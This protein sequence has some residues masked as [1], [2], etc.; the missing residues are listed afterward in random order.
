[1][2]FGTILTMACLTG[3]A[4]TSALASDQTDVISRMQ[5]TID[6]ANK[7]ID[8][9]VVS[10]FMPSVVLV[11]DL[12]P[13]VFRGPAA[14]A[15]S[16]WSKAYGTDSEK[17]EITDFSMKLL[18]PRRVAVSGD[19]AYI[20]LPAIYSFKQRLKPMQTRGII[21]ATLERVNKK[22]LIATWSW[23]GQ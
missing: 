9:A 22:W 17:N 1:M 8:A 10:N 16:D 7:N 5:Q 14:D 11:D 21:T 3:L 12:P 13:Y 18:K 15:I 6:A 23:A 2:S 19:R 20:I 4:A